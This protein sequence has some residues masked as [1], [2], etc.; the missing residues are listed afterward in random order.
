MKSQSSPRRFISLLIAIALFLAFVSV[1]LRYDPFH[2]AL[3]MDP[4]I[5]SY[6]AQQ[7]AQG[8]P[9]HLGV[10][11]VKSSLSVLFG[12]LAIRAGSLTGLAEIYSLRLYMLFVTGLCI[13]AVFLLGTRFSR[14]TVAGIV[15]ALLLASFSRFI[16]LTVNG[17]E[18]KTVMVLFG[19]C[20]LYALTRRAWFW[21][22]MCAA[23]SGLAWQI[24]MGYVALAL[25]L[26]LLQND[27]ARTRLRAAS[28]VLLG[29]ALP[30]AAY[31][32]YFAG[33]GAGPAAWEQNILVPFFRSDQINWTR[34]YLVR[35]LKNYAQEYGN[36][37]LPGV[38]SVAG[39]LAWWFYALRS[40]KFVFLFF[41]SPRTSGTLL[42][43]HGLFL[44]TLIDFQAYPDWIPLL[45]FISLFAGW[46]VVR[47]LLEITRRVPVLYPY[48]GMVVG[49]FAALLLVGVNLS[50]F[51]LAPQAPGYPEQQ[52]LADEL[53]ARLG[54][55]ATVWIMGKNELLFFMRRRNPNRYTFLFKNTDAVIDRLEPD[56]Y[57]RFM[58]EIRDAKPE[59][60]V[61][62]RLRRK[63]MAKP[64]RY[65]ALSQWLAQEYVPLKICLD[66]KRTKFF[67]RA[68]AAPALF[69]A[70]NDDAPKPCIRLARP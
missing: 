43:A 24:G 33:Q 61:V 10:Y 44:Y 20:A 59:F 42:A 57:A 63:H 64:Q 56:G 21:A 60:I 39:I 68:D 3:N 11:E 70:G 12:A 13:V 18:P 30:I 47:V 40:R 35:M 62:G 23:A 31:G 5:Y 25:L 27:N 8:N 49:I 53:N 28:A 34:L 19:L 51:S 58:Q 2:A 65:D 45:P 52:K 55:G 15:S 37:I 1:W 46:L 36:Q 66:A 32:L 7:A 41:K 14:M 67:V 17:V 48:R 29:A 54:P 69:P 16:Q 22:G 50:T 9:P 6:M 38:L 26:A 4:A